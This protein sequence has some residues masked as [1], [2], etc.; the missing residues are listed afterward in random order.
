MIFIIIVIIINKV[1]FI[2][3]KDSSALKTKKQKKDAF[4]KGKLIDIFICHLIN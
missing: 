4:F 2:Y 1:L 3:I